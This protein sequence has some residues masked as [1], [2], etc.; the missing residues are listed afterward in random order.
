L[1]EAI[2]HLEKV[3]DM[4]EK[5]ECR[6]DL[7]GAAY[8]DLCQCRLDKGEIEE[9]E[10]LLNKGLSLMKRSGHRSRPMIFVLI[11]WEE[12]AAWMQNCMK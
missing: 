10:D 4:D 9:A 6:P 8:V 7:A 11:S 1:D 2:A 5:G 12:Y 3:I